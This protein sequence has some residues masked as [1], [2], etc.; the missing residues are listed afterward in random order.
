LIWGGLALA[1]FAI[2]QLV[3]LSEPLAAGR[4]LAGRITYVAVLALLAALVSVLNARTP[5]ERVWAGLMVLLVVVFL[6]PWLEEQT[7]LR[8]AHG[9]SQLHLDAP[10]TIFFGLVVLVGLTNYLPTRF[11]LAA[12]CFGLVFAL[13]YLGLTRVEWPAERR[14]ALWSWTAWSC[15]LGVWVADRSEA[16]APAARAPCEQLWFWFRDHWGVVWA[17]RVRERF[18]RSAELLHWPVK[19]SWFGFE[20]VDVNASDAVT[21]PP[22]EAE[23]ALRGLIRRFAQPWR[24]DQA[25]GIAAAASCDQADSR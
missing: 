9:L 20:P 25:S 12:V 23:A 2:A 1:C 21:T 3:S 24:L 19:L 5:G 13:E 11:G 7:R 6:I 22:Q 4:P 14:A 10:W 15:A 18:N 16:W 17:L 8:R